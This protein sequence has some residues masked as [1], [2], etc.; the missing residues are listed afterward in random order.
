MTVRRSFT[1]SPPMESSEK[2]DMNMYLD[3][4][5]EDQPLKRFVSR[6]DMRDDIDIPNPHR[7]VDRA[8]FRVVRF[9]MKDSTPR[10]Q[11]I[12]GAAGIGKT[13]M[14]WV[15]KDQENYFAAG[16]F[17]AVYVPSPPSPARVPLH[18]HACIVDEAGERLF[19]QAVDMLITK[20][21]G[22]KGVT[23]EVYDY[24]YA[25]ERILVDYPGI[26]ADVVK[27]LLRYRLDPATRD[28][29]RRWLLGD[30]LSDEE[31]GKLGVRTILEE[32]D[33]TMAT[34]KLLAESSEVPILLFVDEM[35]GPYNTYGET[36][37]R[38]FLEVL[39]RMYN[40]SKNIIIIASCLS[41][42]WERIYNLVDGPTRSRMEAP[43]ELSP[44]SRE[45]VTAFVTETMARYWQLQNVESP[46]SPLFPFSESDIDD[47]FQHSGGNP[48]EAIK[49]LIPRL[50]TILFDRPVE[51][52][53]EQDDY[54]IKLT[55]N[56]ITDSI[57][58]ALA[59]AGASSGITVNLKIS[60]E[61]GQKPPAAIVELSRGDVTRY[62]GID[63][64]NVKDWDRSGGVAAFY[65]GKR[66][67]SI[68]DNGTIASAIVAIPAATKGAKFDSLTGEI[69]SRMLVLRMDTGSATSLVQDTSEDKLPH[70]F[71]ETLT[72]LVDT[73]FR[74]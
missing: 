5:R 3:I 28:L 47:A 17:L 46:L 58:K 52:V 60:S 53:A 26:S 22:L 67:A 29:A 55:A 31:I 8:I 64:P 23:H 33:V 66:L 62:I 34:I 2:S 15:L 11:P 39:K 37:E 45:D 20:F 63:V 68:L 27:A 16:R 51:E 35:E 24:T 19:E 43:V 41:D 21:G 71:G 38:H 72:G 13:H 50:D 40:E 69:G 18:L 44:F 61:E 4:L 74:E 49:R 54:M 30:A 9:T 14:Y 32:D 56:V 65:A 73:L 59:L 25:L 57:V 48:R 12:L 36:G 7:D 1:I 6:G 42:V 10:F 70:G